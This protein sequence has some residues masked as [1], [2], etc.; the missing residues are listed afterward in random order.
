MYKEILE[1]KYKETY[2]LSKELKY[3]K[4][5]YEFYKDDEYS[6]GRYWIYET[7][8][9]IIDIHD[10]YIKKDV[11]F[12]NFK[13][14]SSYLYL[15][16]VYAF[17]CNGE[18]FYPDEKLQNNMV[19]ATNM[20]NTNFKMIFHKNF[21]ILSVGIFFKENFLK[22][23]IKKDLNLNEMFFETKGKIL[24]PLKK[25]STEILNC[26][27]QKEASKIFFEAKAKE[28]LSIILDEYQKKK[29]KKK[30]TQD[31]K[32]A[33]SKLVNYI[34]EHFNLKLS[35]EILSE[36]TLMS[37]AKLKRIFKNEFNMSISEFIQKRRMD[38]AQNLLLNTDLKIE[39][40]AKSVGYNSS[41]KFTIYFKKQ[42]GILPSEIRKY[43]NNF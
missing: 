34:N 29:I 22:K 39:S 8:D 33:L 2:K 41:S 4:I 19:Y 27:M 24:I 35:L 43:K 14:L 11:V 13:E 16:S 28:W 25:I 36:I 6:I 23:F 9:F 7:E 3:N 30:I 12:K 21:P 40:I 32:I 10:F 15:Y 5:G 20:K 17:I 1:N 42:K 31:D 18:T 37:Q 26:K 38:I